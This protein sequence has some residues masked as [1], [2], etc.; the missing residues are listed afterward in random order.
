MQAVRKAPR[1]AQLAFLRG[2]PELGGK[3][4]RPAR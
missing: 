2:H 1:E 3:V 4:A